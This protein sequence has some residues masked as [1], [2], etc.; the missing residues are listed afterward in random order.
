VKEQEEKP[1]EIARK[2]MRM[3]ETEK[4]RMQRRP[5]GIE[6]T[7]AFGRTFEKTTRKQWTRKQWTRKQW[8]RTR[9]IKMGRVLRI[10]ANLSR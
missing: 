1:T 6:E 3:V 5:L 4:W 7:V 9:K 10:Y 2:R 8:T